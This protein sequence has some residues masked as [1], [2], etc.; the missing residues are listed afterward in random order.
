[1]RSCL[2]SA[3]IH[4]LSRAESTPTRPA[5]WGPQA[6]IRAVCRAQIPA[7]SLGNASKPGGHFAPALGRL[8]KPFRLRRKGFCP[9]SDRIGCGRSPDHNSFV[10]GFV[11]SLW[12]LAGAPLGLCSSPIAVWWTDGAAFDCS[13][14]RPLKTIAVPLDHLNSFSTLPINVL[15]RRCASCWAANCSA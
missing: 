5:C 10:A 7:C 9:W 15:A 12:T 1:M 4:A 11:A 3:G 14:D 13:L 2:G 8:R 6:S